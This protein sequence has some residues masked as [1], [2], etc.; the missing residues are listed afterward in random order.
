MVLKVAFSKGFDACP[1]A[2][3]TF[4][5]DVNDRA[6]NDASATVRPAQGDV[7]G[8]VEGPE[9]FAALRWPP[10]DDQAL[11]WNEGLYEIGGRGA[12]LDLVEWD[13]GQAR[14]KIDET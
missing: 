14:R 13:L 9:G 11:A 1:E 5:G 6:L 10:D 3:S 2:V 4:T 7:H 8:E 12:H